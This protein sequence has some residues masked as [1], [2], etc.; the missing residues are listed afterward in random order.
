MLNVKPRDADKREG[1]Y[2]PLKT[3]KLIF[4]QKSGYFQ[5]FHRNQRENRSNPG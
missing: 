3:Q 2:I 5:R 4:L 1:G